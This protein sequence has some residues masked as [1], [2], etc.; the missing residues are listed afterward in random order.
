MSEVETGE[1]R[2]EFAA[3][4]WEHG[5]ASWLLKVAGGLIFLL[6][7]ITIFVEQMPGQLSE[8]PVAAARWTLRASEA[9]GPW[10]AP[11]RALGLFDVLSNPLL[12]LL[13]LLV[14]FVL[15]LQL[16]NT[17]AQVWRLYLLNQHLRNAQLESMVPNAIAGAH[18]AGAPLILPATQMLFRARRALAESPTTL[19]TRTHDLLSTHFDAVYPRQQVVTARTGE[20]TEHG[21]QHE[22]G[23]AT[24]EESAK[25]AVDVPTAEPSAHGT[26]TEEVTEE[27]LFAV[28]HVRPALLRPILYLGLFLALATIWAILIWGWEITPPPLAPGVEY[29][30]GSHGLTLRYLLPIEEISAE[31]SVPERSDTESDNAGVES[32]P[33]S[34]AESSASTAL[35]PSLGIQ[36]G[37]QNITISFG[38]SARLN[39]G[40]THIGTQL[41]PP[42]LYLRALDDT[43]R[44]SRLGQTQ[45]VPSI[46]FVFPSPNSEE[47]VVIN[48][49]IGLRI[50]R[51]AGNEPIQTEQYLIEIYDANTNE[52]VNRIPLQRRAT[53]ELVTDN[54]NATVEFI[55]LPSL[56][57]KVDHQPYIWLF[58]PALLFIVIGMV[59]YAYQPAFVA[60]Q[61]APWPIDRTV[62][63]MQS[64]SQHDFAFLWDWVNTKTER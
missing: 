14:I 10:G 38:E 11:L 30:S 39:R 53:A 27:Q 49:M 47:S 4:I 60:F 32:I 20:T 62:A 42:A 51:S 19:R 34:S 24:T 29:R 52:L 46:G 45:A 40:Q 13:L 33:T 3:S 9:Y 8:D 21:P 22:N 58:W 18:E 61:L 59:G 12:Q 48:E 36:A 63:I 41:G 31:T 7:L 35:V 28:R 55:P 54:A 44:I 5:S 17:V 37:D 15:L 43:A 57:V 50:V 25:R 56:M 26:A 23:E 1:R 16:G 64:D 2:T 6:F